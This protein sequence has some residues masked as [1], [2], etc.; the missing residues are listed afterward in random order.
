MKHLGIIGCYFLAVSFKQAVSCH[1][2]QAAGR[3]GVQIFGIVIAE[4]HYIAQITGGQTRRESGIAAFHIGGYQVHLYIEFI[5]YY[6]CKPACLL[7]GIIAKHRKNFY[8][9]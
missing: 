6:L 5:L 7:S 4:D 9:V 3:N 2:Q 8:L 1:I